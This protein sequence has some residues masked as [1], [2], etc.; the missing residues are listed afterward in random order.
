MN[1]DI[2]GDTKPS[3]TFREIESSDFQVI[4][5][6]HE[7]LFPVNYSDTFYQNTCDGIGIGGGKIYSSLAV[8][9]GQVVGFILAQMML[10]PSKCEDKDL[11]SI[12][13]QPK[14]VC[15]VLTLGLTKEYRRSGLGTTLIKRCEEF[16]SMNWECGAVR[17]YSPF[18]IHSINLPYRSLCSCLCSL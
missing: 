5:D 12:D 18:R 11:F 7:E 1:A 10:Y 13:K 3:V 14:Y 15:Y 6:L 2:E 17:L 9:S 8:V 16:A 4:K